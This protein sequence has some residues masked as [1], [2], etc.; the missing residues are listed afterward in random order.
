MKRSL[1]GLSILFSFILVA[2]GGGGS[3]S[4][5]PASSSN[6]PAS[7]TP[8]NVQGQWM[9]TAQS[10]DSPGSYVLIGANLLQT[11]SS[12]DSSAASAVSVIYQTGSN[13][14]SWALGA[15]CGAGQT[16]TSTLN[17][18]ISKGTQLSITFSESGPAGNNTTSATGTISSDGNTM[19]GTYTTPAGCGIPADAGTFS[20]SRVN[21]AGT[22]NFVE[23]L[24]TA[25]QGTLTVTEGSNSSLNV[26]G[27]IQGYSGSL[28]GTYTGNMFSA[29]G[30]LQGPINVDDTVNVIG[31]LMPPGFGSFSGTVV[32]IDPTS[33]Q[34]VGFLTKQ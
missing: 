12:V 2:C 32:L 7:S 3:A 27:N 31:A 30:L 22:Y 24:D 28:T 13:S 29:S 5:S 21:L 8:V 14:L 18:T 17:G 20:A 34:L 19:T 1:I 11:N 23:S 16:D 25:S 9:I 33:D 26:S 4:N 6:P 15:A 10:Q